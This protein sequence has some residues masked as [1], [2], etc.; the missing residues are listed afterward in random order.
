MVNV[1]PALSSP[2]GILFTAGEVTLGFL[3]VELSGKSSTDAAHSEEVCFLDSLPVSLLS[4]F[5]PL[6]SL[7]GTAA[8]TAVELWDPQTLERFELW[9]AC[10]DLNLP[11]LPTRDPPKPSASSSKRHEGTSVYTVSGHHNGGL[12]QY[13]PCVSCVVLL[14]V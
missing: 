10:G 1:P 11:S 4:F 5:F 14:I 9:G 13:K 7:G 3:L 2:A 8:A 6:S 12:N